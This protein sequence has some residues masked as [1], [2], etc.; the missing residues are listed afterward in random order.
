M[1]DELE[2]GQAYYFI[3]HAYYHY[4]AVLKKNLG[5]RRA[6]LTKVRQIHSC[7][8]GWTEFFKNGMAD[9][10]RFDTLADIPSTGYLVAFKWDHPI[11][12]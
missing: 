7:Q 6:S 9:D 11:K 10:T 2:P 1:D 3:V 4:I 8:R 5:V 12:D